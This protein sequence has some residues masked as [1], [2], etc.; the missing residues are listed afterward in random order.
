MSQ[1]KVGKGP[2][3]NGSPPRRTGKWT[4]EEEV[5]AECLI[6]EFKAGYLPVSEGQTLRGF[7]A[8]LLH[9]NPKRIGKKFEKVPGFSGKLA[10]VKSKEKISAEEV[11]RRRDNLSELE[12]RFHDSLAAMERVETELRKSNNER[13]RSG[14]FSRF[15]LDPEQTQTKATD[16]LESLPGIH[17]NFGEQQFANLGPP[18][19]VATLNGT[20]DGTYKARSDLPS[21]TRESALG[22]VN[23]ISSLE[24]QLRQQRLSNLLPPPNY[25]GEILKVTNP[26]LSDTFSRHN[27]TTH[28]PIFGIG[29]SAGGSGHQSER[30]AQFMRLQQNIE[31]SEAV[32][33]SQMLAYRQQ[34]SVIQKPVARYPTES[35]MPP[36]LQERLQGVNRA[37]Q[38]QP[39]IEREQIKRD[40][41]GEGEV[42]HTSEGEKKMPAKKRLKRP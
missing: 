24:L 4:S 9:C 6:A 20:E 11:L 37:H 17:P 34:G 2:V 15:N 10:F 14:N 19:G 18:I 22:A 31:E 5:Y 41:D 26:M 38:Q 23:T 28:S 27:R 21:Y 35:V 32:A 8:K 42:P 36:S 30:L 29:P 16:T 40:R 39:P 25:Q 7:L 1:Q 3:K 33:I 12:R 13:D